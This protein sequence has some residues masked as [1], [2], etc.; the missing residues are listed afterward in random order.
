V[1]AADASVPDRSGESRRATDALF[2]SGPFESGA[3][4]SGARESGVKETGP[5]DARL[6][7]AGKDS[8]RDALPRDGKGAGAG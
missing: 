7:G 1:P 6:E 2:E 4:E 3:R 8:S 5:T